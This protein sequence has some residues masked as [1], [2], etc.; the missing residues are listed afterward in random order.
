M[1]IYLVGFW[2]CMEYKL[3]TGEASHVAYEVTELL[4]DGWRLHGPPSMAMIN[5]SSPSFVQALIK[6]TL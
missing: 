4:E 6:G 1:I 5:G 2:L 3:V